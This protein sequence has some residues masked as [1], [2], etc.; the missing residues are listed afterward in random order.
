MCDDQAP[1][2]ALNFLQTEVSSVVDHTSMEEAAH[3]RSLLTHLLNPAAKSSPSMPQSG[4]TRRAGDDHQE[5][6]RKRS[7]SE[8]TWTS[9]L[10]DEEDDP[11]DEHNFHSR[12]AGGSWI[13][14]LISGMEEDPVEVDLR[15]DSGT[16]APSPDRFK[17][18]TEVFEALVTFVDEY[19][20]EPEGSL[21]D[22]LSRD[23]E[24]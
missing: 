2:K 12:P 16:T 24:M 7:R 3:F 14:D 11:A 5:G 22:R 15:R 9:K 13:S 18:R 4:G 20:K 19:A 1:V 6:P 17:Q 10:D 8:D 21:V 23:D